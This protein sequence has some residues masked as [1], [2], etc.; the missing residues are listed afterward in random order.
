MITGG[1]FPRHEAI[2]F[3]D[4]E[5]VGT[6]RNANLAHDHGFFV[7]N[8]PQDLTDQITGFREVMDRA[9]QP[10]ASSVAR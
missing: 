1:C 3:F 8:H 9:A 6:L 5:T 7:G 10:A 2:K 4:Y